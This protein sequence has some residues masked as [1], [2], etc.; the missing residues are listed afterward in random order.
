[1]EPDSPQQTINIDHLVTE[2]T[3]VSLQKI[4][5]RGRGRPRKIEL[6]P[7]SPEIGQVLKEKAKHLEND[8]LTTLI[9]TRPNS[10]E[11]L[12]Q[13]MYEL[14]RESAS[15]HFERGEAERKG[16]DTSVLSSKKV[17]ALKSVATIFFKKRDSIINDAFDFSSSRFQ[18]FIGWFFVRV[19]RPSAKE[20]ELSSEQINVL[21]DYIGEKLEGEDWHK[22][23]LNYIKKD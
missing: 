20:A 13:L 15:L 8:R 4:T 3:T 17:T 16:Q 2:V 21:F 1:M 9:E 10:L 11:I 14:S 23:A 6:L 7:A 18:R 19:I 5:R 12:D 22:E